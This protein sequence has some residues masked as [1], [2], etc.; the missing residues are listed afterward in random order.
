MNFC[1]ENNSHMF[2][3]HAELSRELKRKC[4]EYIH[5][6]LVKDFQAADEGRKYRQQVE[7]L[8]KRAADPEEYFSRLNE[9]IDDWLLFG[10]TRRAASNH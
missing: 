5:E 9:K 3:Y 4:V 8:E 2:H 1:E 6:H 7:S 10:E